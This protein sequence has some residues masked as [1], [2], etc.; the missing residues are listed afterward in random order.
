[1]LVTDRLRGHLRDVWLTKHWILSGIVYGR[2][3]R[4][5]LSDPYEFAKGRT[6]PVT[7]VW[8]ITDRPDSG[9]RVLVAGFPAGS[10]GTNC[11]IVAPAAG[12]QCVVVDPGQDA[13]DGIA[14]IVRENRRQPVAVLLTHGHLDHTMS[15]VP[16]CGSYGVP[17]YIHPEDRAM[18]D[19]PAPSLGLAPGSPVFGNLNFQEPDEV[20]ELT[21]GVVLDI[22][23]LTTPRAIQGGR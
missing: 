4:R 16:V 14:E 5:R 19:D 11:Y 6:P 9:A 15:V 23:G 2:E 1:L 12:E 13:A 20:R 21:D 18:L 8:T 3:M 10:L 17:A 22:A 7:C